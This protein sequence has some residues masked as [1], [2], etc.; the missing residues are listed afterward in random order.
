MKHSK[1]ARELF[2]KGYN[3]SQSVVGAFCDV[4]GMGLEDALKLSAPFGAG[5]G[6][7]RETCGAV[8]GMFMVAGM[9]YGYSDEAPESKEEH[10]KLIQKLANKFKEKN[11]GTIICR[12]LLKELKTDTLPKPSVRDEKYYKERPCARFVED[13]CDILDELIA[14][15]SK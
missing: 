3:C 6:K 15:K 1:I 12:E 14:E 8:T 2:L 5:M 7:M 10:Y 11:N 4:T 13:A 9:L